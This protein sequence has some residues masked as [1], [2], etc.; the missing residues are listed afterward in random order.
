MQEPI[1]ISETP[2]LPGLQMVQQANAALATIATDF[3]GTSDPAALAAPF[4][5]WANTATGVVSRRNAAGTAW[6][7]VGR[8]FERPFYQSDAAS[9]LIPTGGFKNLLINAKFNINQRAVSGTVTLA[10]GA[11]GHDRWKAGS[12]GCTYT[13]ATTAGVTTIT[14]TAG[15]LVQVVE[16]NN[17]RTGDHV[18]SWTGTATGRIAAGGFASSPVTGAVTGGTNTSIEFGTGTL[19]LPQLEAGL[20]PTSF[21]NRPLKAEM[22]LCLWYAE[23]KTTVASV[24]IFGM[25]QV[26]STTIAEGLLEYTKKRVPPSITNSGA[27][28]V[29]SA[30]G[31]AV[32][33]SSLIFNAISDSSAGIA[34]T[35]NAAA[36]VQGQSSKLIGNAVNATIVIS[37]EL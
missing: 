6:V 36:L 24:R 30:S 26:V 31:S 21:E 20:N 1:A 33:L 8:V 37:S 14:I 34:A 10:A 18:L 28:A 16:G 2:P 13:F 7:E 22:D 19:T 27:I 23:V 25:C 32:G 17:L 15:T 35:A 4:M 11:Y 9:G 3:A 29:T 5:T 12:G